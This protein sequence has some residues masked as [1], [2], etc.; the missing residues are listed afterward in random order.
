MLDTRGG[1]RSVRDADLVKGSDSTPISVAESDLESVFESDSGSV[2]DSVSDSASSS[3]TNSVSRIDEHRGEVL[4]LADQLSDQETLCG[5]LA[6]A[7]YLPRARQSLSECDISAI[8]DLCFD[9]LVAT[10][11]C[12]RRIH[13][14]AANAPMHTPTMA[15]LP[16][17]LRQRRVIAVSD[18]AAEGTV[19]S[20][21]LGGA[22]QCFYLNESPRVLSERIQAALRH[23]GRRASHQLTLGDIHFDIDR[24]LV[25][26]CG[27]VVDLSPKEFQLAYYLFSHRGRIVDNGELMT[28]IWSLPATMDT[29]RIDTA[30][31]RIRKKLQLSGDS[32]WWLKRVRGVGYRLL[33]LHD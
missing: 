14:H 15:C 32:G 5:M 33:Q 30:A 28:S 10:V 23:H 1:K 24:R 6:D 22:D 11:M 3:I 26:L 17:Q 7:G 9:S 27:Q 31:C 29:R 2:P 21:L 8:H 19:V 16:E 4:V 13:G 20:L 12:H 18:C 25:T